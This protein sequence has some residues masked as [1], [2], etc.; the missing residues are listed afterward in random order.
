MKLSN[1][2]AGYGAA[3]RV[4]WNLATIIT[5]RWRTPPHVLM[6]FALLFVFACGDGPN[7]TGVRGEAP[8]QTLETF[9][10]KMCAC[11]DPVCV[12][13]VVVEMAAWSKKVKARDNVEETAKTMQRYNACMA[14]ASRKR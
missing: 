8:H 6:R 1:W 2:R 3:L 7:Q 4:S 14:S 12:K 13:Q 11:R 9:E 10:G 5:V